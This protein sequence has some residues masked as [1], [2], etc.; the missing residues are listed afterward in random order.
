MEHI[1]RLGN[2]QCLTVN[3]TVYVVT[4]VFKSSIKFYMMRQESQVDKFCKAARM[5]TN[6]S[7]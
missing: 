4:S 5:K 1:K 2:V 3:Q 7:S 6:I